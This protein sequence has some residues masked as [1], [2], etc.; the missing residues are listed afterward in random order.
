VDQDRSHSFASQ[1]AWHA[2]GRYWSG[3][4][5]LDLPLTARPASEA[6]SLFRTGV[7][8][9]MLL[10]AFLACYIPARAGARVNPML[11]L[12]RE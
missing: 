3:G 2:Q 7:A 1:F 8:A 4:E 6:A 10:V 9:M 12:R 5:D 11:A